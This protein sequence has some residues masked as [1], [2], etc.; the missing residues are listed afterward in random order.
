MA[1]KRCASS[2]DTT[3]A[4]RSWDSEM[5]SSVPSRPSYFLGTVLRS[6]SSP[7]A[8]S[9]TA[10]DTPPAPK[11]LQRFIIPAACGLRNSRWSLRSSGGCPSAPPRRSPPAK[12]PCGPWR[13]RWLRRSRRAR[14]PAQKYDCVAGYRRLPAHVFRRDCAHHG[15]Y[16]HALG[17][18]AGM[19]QLGDLAGGQAYLVAVGGIARRR[20]GGQLP[21]GQLALSVSPTGRRGSAAPVTRMAA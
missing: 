2:A 19:V 13:S 7:S 4:I 5:A 6:T 16:L 20:G 18:V 12:R 9:P 1:Q 10:T 15:A 11:S 17:G 14:A 21:L 8:S 3:T